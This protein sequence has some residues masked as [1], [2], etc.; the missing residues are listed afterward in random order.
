MRADTNAYL[1]VMRQ[2]KYRTNVVTG[3][4]NSDINMM[5]RVTQ[6]ESL[7]LQ[8]RM[9]I[10]SVALASLSANKDLFE[11]EG[12]KFKEYWKA[13]RIFEDIEAKNPDFFPKP[14]NEIPSGVPG[15]KNE[16]TN[17]EDGFMTRDEMLEVHNR[18]CDFLHAPN[19]FAEERDYR[20]FLRQ[21]PNWMTRIMKLLNS[22]IIRLLDDDIFYIVHMREDEI[23]GR[24]NMHLF[25]KLP[26]DFQVP[27]IQDQTLNQ[28][29]VKCD[30]NS[31]SN[32]DNR[33]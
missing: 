8:L 24:P 18:C 20:E 33:S 13:N 12:S 25:Q 6:A 1:K 2:I 30:T 7:S 32:C 27:P 28:E 22:H 11:A 15:V 5:Y 26:N 4:I 14:I 3:L 17:V 10:E 23:E 31:D 19:P 16:I 29:S 21:A 9:I